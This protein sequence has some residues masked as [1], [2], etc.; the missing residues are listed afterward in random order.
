MTSPNQAAADTVETGTDLVDATPACSA[1][2]N[3]PTG[4]NG[5]VNQDGRLVLHWEPQSNAN[6]WQV[7]EL[8]KDPANTLKA[9]VTTPMS[10]RGPLA[11][12]RYAYGS[13]RSALNGQS[14]MSPTIDV[15]V[16]PGGGGT[17]DVHGGVPID[18]STWTAD[19]YVATTG[20]D[21]NAGTSSSAP[22]RTIAA[23]TAAAQPGQTISVADGVYAGNV[24]PTKGGSSAGF[25]T[26]RAANRLGATIHGNGDEDE[27]SA[28]VIK[29]PYLR[30]QDLVITGKKGTR[31]GVLVG[32]DN[33]EIIGATGSTGHRARLATSAATSRPSGRASS[34]M[35]RWSARL[36]TP[37]FPAAPLSCGRTGRR[38]QKRCN[39]TT[40]CVRCCAGSSA[41]RRS[42]PIE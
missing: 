17:V 7:H 6:S 11:G 5:T 24:T 41:F 1:V 9:T 31:N 30:F 32:A 29:R 16:D 10:T 42:V 36:P 23:A 21:A 15:H 26:V 38:P 35:P 34:T 12:G 22:K 27:Q 8:L 3:R 19:L 4:L 20:S 39:V 37:S 13:S 2:P 28:V 14:P 33:V 40:I 25:I 18:G